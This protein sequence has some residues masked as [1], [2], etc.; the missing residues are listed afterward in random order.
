MSDR[1]N[2]YEPCCEASSKKLSD[3]ILVLYMLYRNNLNDRLKSVRQ[4]EKQSKDLAKPSNSSNKSGKSFSVSKE[5][6]NRTNSFI[7]VIRGN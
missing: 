5:G 6:P 7:D 2:L 1:I 3:K 4:I